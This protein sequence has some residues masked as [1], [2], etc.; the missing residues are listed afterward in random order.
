MSEAAEPSRA[1]VRGSVLDP[2]VSSRISSRREQIE[3]GTPAVAPWSEGTFVTDR[4]KGYL[5]K[6]LAS[7]V[8][9]LDT[10]IN[11]ECSLEEQTLWHLF[12]EFDANLDSIFD[13]L[14]MEQLFRN[15]DPDCSQQTVEVYQSSLEECAT[16]PGE[17]SF[18]DFCKWWHKASAD[19]SNPAATPALKML[20]LARGARDSIKSGTVGLFAQN[21]VADRYDDA[22]PA[23]L[24]C[25]LPTYRET[26]KELR[27]W[28]LQLHFEEAD[29]L[30][31]NWE[32]AKKL[33]NI[34][35]QM[36]PQDEKVLWEVYCEFEVSLNGILE[37]GEVADMLSDLDRYADADSIEKQYSEICQGEKKE[38]ITFVD[39]MKWWF[40]CEKGGALRAQLGV[41]IAA[42]KVKAVGAAFG[43]PAL[44]KRWQEAPESLVKECVEAYKKVATELCDFQS[45]K[46]LEE[47]ERVA[48]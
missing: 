47:A 44:E 18:M 25:L 17:C 1:S 38:G 45:E 16:V 28:H 46:L 34:I 42:S 10:M 41:K 13:R 14:E 33:Y 24:E 40:S 11:K 27:A 12:T 6:Y 20:I 9:E 22:D 2:K 23:Q 48:A 43:T 29:R 36:L 37:K 21:Q 5:L 19:E 30:G 8:K 39:L 3:Q 35:L 15:L 4:W 26:L 32:C 7:V 31:M